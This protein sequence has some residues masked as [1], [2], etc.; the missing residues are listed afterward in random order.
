[1]TKVMTEYVYTTLDT[2]SRTVLYQYPRELFE[3]PVRDSRISFSYFEYYKNE[4]THHEENAHYL[5]IH[6]HEKIITE[7]EAIRFVIEQELQ[8]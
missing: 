8:A 7:E 5:Y 4:W 1:M 3:N 6:P 2:R